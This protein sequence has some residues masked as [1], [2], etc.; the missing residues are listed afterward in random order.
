MDCELA[1]EVEK[2]KY[3]VFLLIPQRVH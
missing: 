1:K 3:K 2:V